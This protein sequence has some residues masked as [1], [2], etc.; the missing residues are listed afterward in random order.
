MDTDRPSATQPQAQQ[1]GARARSTSP[2]AFP[3]SS[4]GHPSSSHDSV[5]AR[6]GALQQPRAAA[7]AGECMLDAPCELKNRN[8]RVP[9]AAASS[10]PMA[11]PSSSASQPAIA[12]GKPLFGGSGLPSS[13]LSS[14]AGLD[15]NAGQ[16]RDSPLFFPGCVLAL[17]T[18]LARFAKEGQERRS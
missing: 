3:S 7:T 8:R 13:G 11:F 18:C 1:Q 17:S 6:V 10:S 15:A 16:R 2:L 4:A 12:R 5:P 14:D 9:S